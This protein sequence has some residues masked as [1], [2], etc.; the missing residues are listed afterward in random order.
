[1]WNYPE[2]KNLIIDRE[3]VSTL[4]TVLGGKAGDKFYVVA[5]V[6]AMSFMEDEIKIE[7]TSYVFLKVPLSV[8]KALIERGEA[9]SLKQPTSENDVNEVIDAVGYD[10][11]S[12][13][14]VKVKYYRDEPL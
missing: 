8:L 9:G 4:H 11:I 2:Q 5:P 14:V 6:T 1:M 12:Q 3:Y 13:P 7:N 10:F